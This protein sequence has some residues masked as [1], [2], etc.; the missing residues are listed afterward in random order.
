MHNYSNEYINIP[1]LTHLERTVWET[2]ELILKCIGGVSE[3]VV[4]EIAITKSLETTSSIH[5]KYIPNEKKILIAKSSLNSIQQFLSSLLYAL[6]QAISGANPKT[7][8]FEQ[9]LTNLL[10]IV[11]Q[12]FVRLSK[13]K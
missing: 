5:S 7:N 9:E 8:E 2:K 4:V 11:G 13:N 6:A 12:E 10:G 1:D 3:D